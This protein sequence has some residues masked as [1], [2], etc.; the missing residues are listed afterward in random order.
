MLLKAN[1][2]VTT[3]QGVLIFVLHLFLSEDIA[4]V[5]R[6][7]V[8]AECLN[9]KEIIDQVCPPEPVIQ[10]EEESDDIEFPEP[11]SYETKKA[12]GLI[13]HFVQSKSN[14]AKQCLWLIIWKTLLTP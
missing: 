6:D 9:D 4:D 5:D 2:T 11:A 8:A 10:S 14:A 1:T 7:V 3:I 13:K 12:F